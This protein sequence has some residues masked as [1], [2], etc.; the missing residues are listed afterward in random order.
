M[1]RK[2]IFGLM[3]AALAPT[4]A[5][6]QEVTLQPIAAFE[7]DRPTAA[8]I[9]RTG[10]LFV[11]L[12]F[13]PF[14]G[15]DQVAT[16]V[17]VLSDGSKRAY[18]NAEWNRKAVGAPS[19]RF[20]NV[21]SLTVDGQGFLWALDTGSPRRTGVVP[22]GAKLV[23]IDTL[24]DKVVRSILIGPPALTD[25]DSYLN[26]VRVDA[27]RQVAYIT[28]SARGGIIVVD[29]VRSSARMVLASPAPPVAM[30][31]PRRPLIVEGLTLAGADGRAQSLATDG[32]ALSPDGN[33][34]YF[35][36]R[37]FAGSSRLYSVRTS[38]LR[39]A[40]M[41]ASE[42][43]QRVADAGPGVISDG[44]EFR[45]GVVYYTD[46]ER[47]AIA[48]AVPGQ[49]PQIVAQSPL[50]SWPDGIAFDSDGSMI[51]AVAQFHRVAALNAGQER[52]SPPYMV[53]RISNRGSGG[54]RT[55]GTCLADPSD[56][57]ATS[58]W[59]SR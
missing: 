25:A 16:V 35:T 5:V 29:L 26:D 56:R 3:L 21:Q 8:V 41:S 40:R 49:P 18:P 50:L 9:D 45:D 59:K 39:D 36:Y 46:L 58:D 33:V 17:E 57:S 37:P 52:G 19:E 12:P 43:A 1:T 7:H 54:A 20:L 2:L 47:G 53:Y 15:A 44:I 23:Q 14:S 10:R 34:L 42:L 13:G 6:S 55:P 32:I 38:D 11:S 30:A 24:R 28:D 51:V 31:E 27:R 22:G 48:C 4:A